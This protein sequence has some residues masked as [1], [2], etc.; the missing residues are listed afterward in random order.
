MA[1]LNHP[2]TSAL[3]ATLARNWA[4]QVRKSASDPWLFVQGLTTVS[5]TMGDKSRQ[6]AGDIHGGSYTGQIATEA[7]WSLEL[8]LQRKI[9]AAGDPDPGVELLRSL[10]GKLGAEELVHVRFWRTDELPDSYQGRAGVTF[11]NAAGDKAALMGATVTLTGYQGY[12]EPAK[13]S[14]VAVN[15]VQRIDIVSAP[16]TF[17]VKMLA[18]TSSALT[19]SSMTNSSLQT[20]LTGL[21]SIGSGNVAVTGDN[22]SGYV[23]TYQSGLAGQDVPLIEIVDLVGGTDPEVV[24][25]VVTEGQPAA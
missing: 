17:K 11:A 22:V 14:T 24:A 19:V 16:T 6:D 2:D 20:A 23:L 21:A 9:D 1:V 5:P 10:Q 8:G 7:S 13:P 12:T 3:D 4:V 15:E 25:S 18:A